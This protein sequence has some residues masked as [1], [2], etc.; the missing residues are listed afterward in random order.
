MNA[1]A[2]VF[3]LTPTD[4]A[5]GTSM[6][7]ATPTPSSTWTLSATLTPTPTATSTFTVSNSPTNSSSATPTS[8]ATASPTP[9]TTASPTSTATLSASPTPTFTATKTG[10]G[11]PTPTATYTTTD[12]YTNSPTKTATNT[13]TRTPTNTTTNSATWTATS[14]PTITRTPTH[15]ATMTATA[16]AT[17]TP[18]ITDT[19][20][21]T[22]TPTPTTWPNACYM[23]GLTGWTT[24]TN[25][26]SAAADVACNP[27]ANVVGP[28]LAPNSNGLLNMVP[29]GQTSA[30]Q[31]FSGRGDTGH[32]DYARVCGTTTV[33]GAGQCCLSF[34]LAGIFE[35]YH[36]V[37]NPAAPNDDAYME[38]QVFVGGGQCGA[39]GQLVYD[40]LYNWTYLVGSGLVT[41]DGLVGNNAGTYGA[42]GGCQVNPSAGTG[43]GVFPWTQYT[44]NMC[45]YAG[46]QC[47]I[48]VSEYDCNEGGHYGWGYFDCPAWI[49]CPNP[50]ITLTKA[51]SPSGQV[52]EGQT[53]TYTLSYK[54]TGNSAISGVVVN[55]TIP[56]GTSLLSNS[57]T[58][59]PYEPV[60]ALIGQD[61]LW[62]IGYLAAG[63]SG[64][65]SFGVTVSPLPPGTCAGS[66]VNIAE[67][68][69]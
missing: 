34:W 2:Q 29:P 51:N 30:I 23:N 61:L 32:G 31:L 37:N 62:N 43:W 16:T 35:N 19:P 50:S 55:D 56:T 14:T 7:S 44:L 11:T 38:V 24:S 40:L 39:G 9:T 22:A 25:S 60:T 48:V 66:I 68:P 27:A 57:V 64:T 26:R 63:A 67:E 46:Q 6:D 53:I 45:Q 59:A 17:N 5:T 12:T 20:T 4:T 41:L 18:T 8:S 58:S 42:G 33:P 49:S 21:I 47:T 10:T 54:N 36:Y 65:L 69:K 1:S 28:G 13:P 3:T 15:T 52:S